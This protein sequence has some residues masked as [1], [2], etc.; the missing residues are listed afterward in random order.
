MTTENTET[1]HVN[2]FVTETK[3]IDRDGVKIGI[4][5]GYIATWDLDRGD[6]YYQDQFVKGCFSESIREYKTEKR[7][8]RFKDHHDRTVGGWQY[9]SLKEDAR[10][11]F[12]IAEINL[13]VQQGKEVYSMA[14][15]GVLTDFSI[16]FR[17]EEK[18]VD[19]TNKIRTI[20]KAKVWEGS[21][22]DEPMNPKANITA[23]KNLIAELP[24]DL[25]ELFDYTA[26]TMNI[27]GNV[28]GIMTEE[29]KTAV[30]EIFKKENRSEIIDGDT[31]IIDKVT[32][33]ELTERQLESIMSSNNAMLTKQASK[34]LISYL[35]FQGMRDA[36]KEKTGTVNEDGEIKARL[37]KLKQLLETN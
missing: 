12:G 15:Q 32:V 35:N 18:I 10:G 20:T 37:D 16:G 25:K 7:M 1:K 33:K 34:T 3:Q 23:V 8:L 4:V 29:L 6:Y 9:E 24:D 31:L 30:N 17:C 11:L 2:G 19:E 5:E 26:K 27:Y 21:I 14:K 13:D 28:G 22:V 36:V